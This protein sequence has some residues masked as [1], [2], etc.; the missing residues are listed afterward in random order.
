METVR[1]PTFLIKLMSK[2]MQDDILAVMREEAAIQTVLPG[3]DYRA[4]CPGFAA[5]PLPLF[6]DEGTVMVLL[7]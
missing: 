7:L 5:T 6:V 2:F 3:Q 1:T 4:V